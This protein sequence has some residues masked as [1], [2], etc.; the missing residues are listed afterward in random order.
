MLLLVSQALQCYKQALQSCPEN[1][2]YVLK[3]KSLTKALHSSTRAAA[4]AAKQQVAVCASVMW[5]P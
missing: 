5:R 4:K 1:D 3:I 2:D